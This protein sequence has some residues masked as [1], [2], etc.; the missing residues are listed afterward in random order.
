MAVIGGKDGTVNNGS[1]VGNVKNWSITHTSNNSAW[2]SSSTGGYKNR[3][4]GTKDWSGTITVARDVA[5]VIPFVV[6]NTYTLN[7]TENGTKFYTGNGI[8]DS[9]AET[10]DVD[11]GT[12]TDV[13]VAF[14]AAGALT[15]PA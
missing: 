5:A 12:Q 8:V 6:G 1:A 10:I 2:G 7:L 4:P 15:V 13:V 11:N 3:V 14:S 9:V